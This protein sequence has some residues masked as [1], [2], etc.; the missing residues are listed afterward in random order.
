MCWSS[1][2]RLGEG[3]RSGLR[4]FAGGAERIAGWQ[5]RAAESL[6]TAMSRDWRDAGGE[7][8]VAGRDARDF[9]EGP[10][11]RGVRPHDS[12]G[13]A[14]DAWS[15]KAIAE[16]KL[17][18]HVTRLGCRANICLGAMLRRM[19]RSASRDGLRA[20]KVYAFVCHESRDSLTPF[21]N[22]AL[23]SPQTEKEDVDLHAKVFREA[24][25]NWRRESGGAF[26]LAVK[27]GFHLLRKSR[28][29][30]I[31]FIFNFLRKGAGA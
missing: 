29:R 23:M 21:H 20:G 9:D 24:V 12:D 28:S 15:A 27:R 22:M 11:Q 10:D 18:W 7:R 2:R 8:F 19:G 1:A 26:G 13:G 4:I 14:L 5:D 6:K 16:A 30:R 25:R 3:F 17:S 31:V